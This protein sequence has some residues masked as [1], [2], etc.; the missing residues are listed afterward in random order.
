M[1][2]RNLT[3]HALSYD[4]AWDFLISERDGK[5]M[6]TVK[7]IMGKLFAGE[8]EVSRKNLWMAGGICLLAGVVVGLC[9]APWTHGIN[10]I[11]GN[12]HNEIPAGFGEEE[13]DCDCECGCE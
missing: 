13:C 8:V 11:C 12:N 2:P 4:S 10:I 5:M 6:K 1:E 9:C 3:S 7:E